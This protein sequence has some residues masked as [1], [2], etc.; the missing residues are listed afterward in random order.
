MSKMQGAKKV[1]DSI[2]IPTALSS[3]VKEA[4]SEAS[5]TPRHRRLKWYQTAVC[6]AACICLI[7]VGVLNAFPAF[8]MQVYEVPVL[9]DIA[10]VFTFREY[11]IEDEESYIEVRMP[12]IETQSG[13]ELDQRINYE[14]RQKIDGILE[15]QEQ[16][17]KEYHQA[18][19]ETGGKE[20]DFRKILVNIDYEVT[21]S[22]E[23]VV[24]FHITKSE[25]LANAYQEQF[26]YNIDLK[27]G[28]DITLSDMLGPNYMEVANQSIKQQI[29][30]RLA[31]DENLMYFGYG[32]DTEML[33]GRFESIDPDQTFYINS[34]GHV[35]ITFEKYAI[36]P[37]YM[38]IQEFEVLPE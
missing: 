12:A 32:S 11:V 29:Q 18:F 25:T 16:R 1:Y 37:G 26:Y 15:E 22:N 28:K 34:Q 7:F 13:S 9:G 38:G 35:V 4:I 10:Q 23:E 20:E 31:Q 3:K 14:I 8:A 6:T 19:L 30:E 17:A 21:C 33:A 5:I 24:S 36:A 2:R 27:T